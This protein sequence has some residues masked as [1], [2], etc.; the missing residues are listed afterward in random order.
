MLHVHM[1]M[2]II[3]DIYLLTY[4]IT[5]FERYTFIDIICYYLIDY[6]IASLI[7]GL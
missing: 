3:C 4:I 1:T 5:E 6:H 2:N 7:V